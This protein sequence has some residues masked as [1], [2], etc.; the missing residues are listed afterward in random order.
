METKKSVNFFF[1]FLVMRTVSQKEKN[2][3][4]R[5]WSSMSSA[6]EKS[7]KIRANN[8]QLTVPCG[9]QKSE[10]RSESI[11]NVSSGVPGQSNDSFLGAES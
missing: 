8:V 3:G 1:F 10:V 9:S 5:K 4:R 6:T 7:S 11:K 2:L